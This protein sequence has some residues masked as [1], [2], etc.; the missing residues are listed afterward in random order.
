MRTVISP[1]YHLLVLYSDP[2]RRQSIKDQG[3]NASY[4]N[5]DDWYDLGYI[6]QGTVGAIVGKESDAGAAALA[7]TLPP[8]SAWFIVEEDN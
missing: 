3:L 6:G 4:D 8:Y 1:D 7:E 5:R 2:A